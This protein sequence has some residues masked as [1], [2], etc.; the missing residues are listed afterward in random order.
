MLKNLRDVIFN[1]VLC[2]RCNEYSEL[3]KFG[4]QK[5]QIPLAFAKLLHPVTKALNIVQWRLQQVTVTE[6]DEGGNV[7]MGPGSQLASTLSY[8]NRPLL[9]IAAEWTEPKMGIK[10]SRSEKKGAMYMQT[11]LKKRKRR[12]TR[13][14]QEPV[15]VP[16]T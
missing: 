8:R 9:F 10:R 15:Q 7:V 6:I 12:S 1:N 16:M 13:W 3:G 14:K 5:S 11:S 4:I 2:S